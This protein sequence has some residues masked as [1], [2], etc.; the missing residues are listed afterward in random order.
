MAPVGTDRPDSEGTAP[1]LLLPLLN[2]EA[3]RTAEV[4]TAVATKMNLATPGIV[5]PA[6]AYVTC[7]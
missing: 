6:V 3:P 7:V 1:L 2:A 5:M 4:A